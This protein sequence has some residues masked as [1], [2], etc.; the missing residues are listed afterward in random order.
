MDDRR[1]VRPRLTAEARAAWERVLIENGVTWSS[2][3]E[4]LGQAIAAGKWTPPQGA[5]AAARK[6]D[7][8]RKSR[9]P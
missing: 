7:F 6:L 1:Q 3:F 5:I 9:R 2:M 4:A 8:E